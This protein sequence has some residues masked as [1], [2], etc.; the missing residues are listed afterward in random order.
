MKLSP[1]DAI[2]AICLFLIYFKSREA[3]NRLAELRDKRLALKDDM[4]KIKGQNKWNEELA[5]AYRQYDNSL[6]N[7]SF[8]WIGTRSFAGALCGSVVSLAFRVS[9]LPGFVI[10]FCI[11]SP[12]VWG[13]GAAIFGTLFGSKRAKG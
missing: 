5:S 12:R 11:S 7:E 8:P 6:L 10:G 4:G 3:N 13:Y 9:T 1:A 2:P